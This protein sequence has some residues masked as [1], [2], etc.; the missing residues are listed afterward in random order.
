[1]SVKP[2]ISDFIALKGQRKIV[3]LTAYSAPMAHALDPHCDL[4]LV[5]DSVA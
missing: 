4:L 3:C 2:E 5:G 1:M